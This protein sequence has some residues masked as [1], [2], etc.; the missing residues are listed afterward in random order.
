MTRIIEALATAP[1]SGE[2]INFSKLDMEYGLWRMVCVVGEYRKFAYVL[3]NQQESPTKL[4]IPSA[5]QMVWTLSSC[6]FHVVS[7]TA[8]AKEESYDHENV[9]KLP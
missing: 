5:L 6:F 3:P 1:L 9:G 7:K 8:R 4:I 2:P